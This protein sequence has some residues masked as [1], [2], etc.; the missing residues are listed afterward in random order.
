M[1][2]TF[3]YRIGSHIIHGDETGIGIIN[4]RIE[5]RIEIKNIKKIDKSKLA[6]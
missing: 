2:L 6:K 5:I 4:E 3:N 1:L